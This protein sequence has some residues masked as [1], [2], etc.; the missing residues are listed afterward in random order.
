MHSNKEPKNI[1]VSKMKS[2]TFIT[3]GVVMTL[4]ATTCLSPAQTPDPSPQGHTNGP[5]SVQIVTPGEGETFLL[6]HKIQICALSQNFT[7][8][9]AQVEFFAGP[10][11]LGVVTNPP[12]IWVTNRLGVFPIRQTSYS[13]TWSN[14]A[15]GAYSLTAVATDNGGAM[16]T[17]V[18]VDITVVTN[19]PPVVKVVSPD[20]GARF[21]SPAN[22]SLDAAAKDPDGTVTQVEFFQGTTN[23]GVVTNGVTMTNELGKVQTLYGLTWSSVPPG[24]YTLTA[25]ATDNGGASSTSAPV[26]VT[27]V[28]PPPPLV[29]IVNPRNGERFRAPANMYIATVARYFT[30]PIA[31]VQFLAGTNTLGVATNSSWPT[32][33]WTN[34]PPGDYVLTTVATDTGGT[35]ATSAPV[36]IMVLTN[37]PHMPTILR[38][39]TGDTTRGAFKP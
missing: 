2:C 13:L 11:S 23:L 25:V 26:E 5:P 12:V 24:A 10:N 27:V 29:R 21:Y 39:L 34:V 4:C 37:W 14:V 36:N 9:V 15:P 35:T 18:A 32:F 38:P 20:D 22:I 30:K 3:A 7:D 28:A 33:H 16:T 1:N 8:A 6:G 17:S 19:L 31:T